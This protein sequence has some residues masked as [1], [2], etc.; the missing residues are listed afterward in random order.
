M[1]AMSTP[2]GE[3]L[4]KNVIELFERIFEVV[5]IQMINS[6]NNF[7]W[8]SLSFSWG[9]DLIIL[10]DNNVCGILSKSED[11]EE[12]QDDDFIHIFWDSIKVL[13]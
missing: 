4:H 1:F 8:A 12:C 5:F 11:N 9:F 3:E 2:R 13:K 7:I 10:Y 6:I